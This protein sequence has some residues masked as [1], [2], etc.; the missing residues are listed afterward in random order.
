[1]KSKWT[2]IRLTVEAVGVLLIAIFLVSRYEERIN[3]VNWRLVS[4]VFVAAI[5]LF[6]FYRW[7]MRRDNTYD[8]LDMFMLNGHADLDAHLKVLSFALAVWVIVQQ[9][10][11]KAEVTA[12]VLGVLG[13]FVAGKAALGFSDAIKSRGPP[14]DQSRDIN[15]LPNANI[16]TAPEQKEPVAASAVSG[17]ERKPTKKGK[18]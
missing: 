7:Q 1:M 18:K 16:Q 6:A 3:A 17:V 12:L 14:V 5:A 15:V 9:A 13:F 4:I 10:L 11:A 8:A 2:A